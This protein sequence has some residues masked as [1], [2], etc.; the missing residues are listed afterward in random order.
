M[1]TMPSSMSGNS[2]SLPDPNGLGAEGQFNGSLAPDTWY[3]IAF[4]VDLAAPAGGQLSKYVNGV[5]VA[6]QSL[7][8][9]RGWAVRPGPGGLALHDRASAAVDSRSPA[10]SA[11]SSSSMAG[12][13]PRPS[14]P[15][16]GPA[17]ASFRPATRAVRVTNVTAN[18]SAGQFGLDWR[19]ERP[20]PGADGR[21]PE[22]SWIGRPFPTRAATAP[23]RFRR[24]GG[25]TDFYRVMQLQPDIQVGQ[26]PNSEQSLPSKQILR[27]PGPATPVRRPP[28][29]PGAFARRQDCVHQE[30]EQ[31]AGRGR[32]FLDAAPDV[33]YPG[34]GASM[35][36]IAVSTDGS[37]VYVTGAGNELYDWAVGAD[38]SGCLLQDNLV[39]GWLLP[40]WSG[41][42]PR[43]HQGI[44]VP[45]DREHSWRG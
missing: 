36:G 34:S 29:G 30:H 14:P 22:P 43:R 8:R 2:A 40:L 4:A 3:R 45:F 38:R 1:A 5:K 24:L 42:L 9:R 31:S 11:A 18:S 27:A 39:A 15:S 25:A 13:R 41:G 10:L 16:A 21:Q 37:H 17:P 12:C 19:P 26:L 44:R 20:V 28:G 35:H 23:S 33:S 7:V 6:S 32:G